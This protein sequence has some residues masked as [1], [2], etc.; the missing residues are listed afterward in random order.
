MD[1][2]LLLAKSLTLLYRESMIAEKTENSSDLVRTVIE[3]I[4][5][6]EVDLGINP[7]FQVI[8]NLKQTLLEM[9]ENPKDF[10]Y[11]QTELLQRVKM[12]CASDDSFYQA[13]AQGVEP[14]LSEA[15]LKR[16][17]VAIRKQLMTHFRE[18]KIQEII[19]KA[20]TEFSFN[21]EKIKD[22]GQWIADLMGGLD[23]FQINNTSKDP[24]VVDE[25]RINADEN[26]PINEEIAKTFK[27]L[28][29][30]D[31]GFGLLRT[32]WQGLNR[33]IQ[34]GFRRGEEVVIGALQ[35][36]FKTG[37]TLS[38]FKQMA[39]YNKPY[40]FN[41]TKKPLLLR[42]SFEDPLTNNFKFLFKQM[43][44]Q[45]T[46]QRVKLSD[47][48]PEEMSEYVQKALTVNGFHVMFMHVNPTDWTY[49]H[50]CNKITELE[51]DGYEIACLMV[52]YLSMI[53]TTGITSTVTGGD[54][55]ELFRR[56]RNFCAS[57]KITFITPH[58]LSTEA[59]QLLRDG[60]ED[61]VRIIPEKGYY[62]KCKT[63]DQEVDLEIY[64]H[65]EKVNGESYLTIQ[66]GK[67]RGRDE[68][69]EK[70]KYMVLKFEKIATIPDDINGPDSTRLK[71]GG[72]PIGSGNEVPLWSDDNVDH[73]TQG[74]VI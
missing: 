14:E 61:F 21:R 55:R 27:Q 20:Y 6:P 50:L 39:L 30:E 31:N 1:N 33:M 58:Q 38:V 34:E 24:A 72:G 63:I 11:E 13:I 12:N 10:E 28:K 68:L 29:D 51:A 64:I 44:E 43:K 53:P 22:V 8:E 67:H 71:V 25:V 4:R 32:G 35:H 52:D 41:V 62:D 40:L 74:L 48:T 46:G 3:G 45:E 42:I 18:L 23:A 36:K 69:P 54:I 16:T 56:M 73:S 49:R 70:Y 26:Q 65:I 57:R 17:V 47:Y 19:K 37:F 7:E 59:K 2:K 5:K 66:R 9:C 15:S 60:R